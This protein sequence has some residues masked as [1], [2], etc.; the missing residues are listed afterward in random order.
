MYHKPNIFISSCITFDECRYDGTMISDE[1]VKRLKPFINVFRVCPE[2]AVGFTSP[3]ESLRLI[4]PKGENTKL[5]IAKTGED[6]TSRMQD[7]GR[8]YLEKLRNKEIDG[9]IMKAKSPTCGIRNVKKY[10]G[11]GKAHSKGSSYPGIFGEMVLQEYQDIPVENERR[12]SNFNI[13]EN[14]FVSIF[15]LAYF[16]EVKKNRK[17]KDLVTFH[18]VNKYLFMTYHQGILKKMGNIVAN[19][20]KM[21][22]DEVINDYETTLKSLS[23]IHI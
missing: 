15:T 17:Y 16:R 4:E 23:L 20:E 14:F 22:F 12:L 13:R 11:I 21:D 7:F 5:V 2:L 3:R 1:T 9:F 8:G 6:Y 18:S 19:H 10:Y